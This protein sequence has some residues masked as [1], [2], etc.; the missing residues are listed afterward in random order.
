MNTVS[1]QRI[2]S[3]IGSLEILHTNFVGVVVAMLG[4][5]GDTSA[6]KYLAY[7]TSDLDAV[8]TRVSTL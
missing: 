8:A 1:M 7:R 2:H 6:H 4:G 3:A 5:H